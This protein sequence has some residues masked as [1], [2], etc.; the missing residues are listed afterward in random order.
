MNEHKEQMIKAEGSQSIMNSFQAVETTLNGAPVLGKNDELLEMGASF[1]FD[2][3]QVVRREFFAH[4]NEPSI[5]FNN[6]KFYVNTAC[7][8]KFPET[9]YVQVLVNRNTKILAL[10]PCGEGERDSFLWC[11]NSKGKRKP[12]QT[13][14]RL[15]FAKIVSLMNWNPDH[16]YKLTGKLVQANGEYLIAFDLTATEVYQRTFVEGAKPKTSR[17]PVFPSEW[18]EQFGLPFKEHRQSMQ[19]NIFEGYAIYAIKENFETTEKEHQTQ[20]MEV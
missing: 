13:T 7:L 17:T 12:K 1:D 14:C 15:F 9:D 2:G 11:N 20:T 19:I 6:Y 18:Q 4:L 16:R 3:F 8:T 10:R 5:S